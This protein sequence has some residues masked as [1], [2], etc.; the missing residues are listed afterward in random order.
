MGRIEIRDRLK[1]IIMEFN[2]NEK[3]IYREYEVE[4]VVLQSKSEYACK[5]FKGVKQVM[6]YSG[7]DY[8]TANL[9]AKAYIDGRYDH[10]IYLEAHL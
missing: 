8:Q 1:E 2:T 3:Y 4:I 7:M 10:K 5:I 6:A 9:V